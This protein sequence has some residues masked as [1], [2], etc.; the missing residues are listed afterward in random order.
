MNEQ[1]RAPLGAG[2]PSS[3]YVYP[4]AGRALNADDRG[5]YIEADAEDG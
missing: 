5:S 4:D 1:M 2:S 3:I